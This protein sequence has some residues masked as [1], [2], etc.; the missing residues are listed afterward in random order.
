MANI[1]TELAKLAYADVE[2]ARGQAAG[3]GWHVVHW[4]LLRAH[5]SCCACLAADLVRLRLPWPPPPPSQLVSGA[6]AKAYYGLATNYRGKGRGGF[7]CFSRA[8]PGW[9]GCCDVRAAKAGFEH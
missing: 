9:R 5:H 2:E 3:G 4:W 8:V 7:G 6:E 1:S